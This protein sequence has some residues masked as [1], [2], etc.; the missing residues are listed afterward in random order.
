MNSFVD[1][2]KNIYIVN[3]V[4]LLEGLSGKERMVFALYLQGYNERLLHKVYCSRKK[5]K[6]LKKRQWIF[7]IFKGLKNVKYF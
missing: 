6:E 2:D 4:D 7:L 1:A 5:R 3:D